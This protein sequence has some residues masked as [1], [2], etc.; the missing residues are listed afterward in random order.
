MNVSLSESGNDPITGQPFEYL[1]G[2]GGGSLRPNRVGKPNTS[3]DPTED[4]LHFLDVNAFSLPIIN[5]PGNAARNVAWGPGF[6]N[7]D[8]G[9][10]KRFPV[11]E[12]MYFDFRF[13]MF[14]TFNHTNFKNPDGRW[15]SSNF[16]VVN[17][18][19]RAP[20]DEDCGP[21][22]VLVR[23]VRSADGSGGQRR[24]AQDDQFAW[25]RDCGCTIT[26]PATALGGHFLGHSQESS[27]GTQSLHG[28]RYCSWVVADGDPVVNST[29]TH[30]IAIGFVHQPGIESSESRMESCAQSSLFFSLFSNL[31]GVFV[32]Q[33]C[34]SAGCELDPARPHLRSGLR[35]YRSSLALPSRYSPAS[36]LPFANKSKKPF[37]APEKILEM[38]K[39]M[40][41]WE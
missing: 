5:T 21:I 31:P 3:I 32:F 22:C 27:S 10:T 15:D 2:S 23:G 20:T 33:C 12:R 28:A 30:Y 1:P 25:A 35:H 36:I 13:E 37:E 39:P 24:R 7:I 34:S 40:A 14:N 6:F 18:R 11:S 9:V 4:R 16:G 29:E 19:F 26:S 8:L 41:G 17:R 38:P